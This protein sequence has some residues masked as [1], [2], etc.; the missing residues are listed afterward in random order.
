MIIGIIENAKGTFSVTM[1]AT[2]DGKTKFVMVD[3]KG[4]RTTSV[5]SIRDIF[6]YHDFS[7]EEFVAWGTTAEGKRKQADILLQCLPKALVEKYRELEIQEKIE[8]DKRTPLISDVTHY[9]KLLADVGISPLQKELLESDLD[10]ITKEIND[11]LLGAEEYNNNLLIYNEY[12]SKLNSWK[13][14][15]DTKIASYK[16]QIID[17]DNEIKRLQEKKETISN[18]IDEVDMSYADAIDG[19]KEVVEPKPID[20]EIVQKAKD[21]Q[22]LIEDAQ[23]N[24]DSYESTKSKYETSVKEK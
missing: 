16:Q 15:Y 5:T 23:R 21:M 9:K 12:K 2:K 14:A 11:T 20:Q 19:L 6:C 10:A 8:Y 7:V 4:L 24:K 18:T 3:E 22:K 17:I 1:E 13:E